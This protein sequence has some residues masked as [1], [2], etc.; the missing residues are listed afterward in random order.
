M[1]YLDK[2]IMEK[3][4]ESC[5]NSNESLLDFGINYISNNGF[6]VGAN[7]GVVILFEFR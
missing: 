5:W 3:E 2:T 1:F 6:D 7:I 4:T